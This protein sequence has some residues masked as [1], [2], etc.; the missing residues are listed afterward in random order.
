MVEVHQSQLRNGLCCCHTFITITRAVSQFFNRYWSNRE[1]TV[2]TQ[3]EIQANTK[4][5]CFCVCK[6]KRFMKTNHCSININIHTLSGNIKSF[7]TLFL[8]LV[9]TNFIFADNKYMYRRWPGINKSDENYVI[10]D[11]LIQKQ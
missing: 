1:S 8:K 5:F 3:M 7:S 6:F 10:V 2:D 4:C 11:T 9:Q